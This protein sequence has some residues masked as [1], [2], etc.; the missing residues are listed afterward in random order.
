MADYTGFA[1]FYDRIMG[2]RGDE[3]ARIRTYISKYLP[4]ARSLL[5]LGCGTGALLAG[6]APELRVTGL[7]RSPQMLAIAARAVPEARLLQGDITAFRLPDRFD[8]IICMFDTL[9]HV[10]SLAGWMS[11]FSCVHEHLADGGLFIFDVNTAGR[12]RRLDGAPPYLDEFDGNVVVM[13]VRSAGDRLSLWRTMI[14]EHQQHD[15]YRL[16]DERIY[17]LAVPLAEIRAALAGRFEPVHEAS[18]DGSPVSDD[19]DRVFFT[20]RRQ[21]L[22]GE[23]SPAQ[24]SP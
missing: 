15:I 12:L 23:A 3:I 10:Q 1:A 9:N 2:D 4:G 22:S 8:V 6:L 19:S 11:L 17:E 7:D 16:H 14:F 13:T 20:Y 24:H 21:G 18:L 5:E